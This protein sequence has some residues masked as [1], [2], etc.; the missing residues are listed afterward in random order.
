M[1]VRITDFGLAKCLEQIGDE[2]HASGGRMPI[3]WLAIESI[4]DKTFSSK[5]DIWSYAS[6]ESLMQVS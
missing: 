1:L 6:N 3:K 2:Y 4:G 5:S